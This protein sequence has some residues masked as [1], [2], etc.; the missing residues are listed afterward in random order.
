MNL[1]LHNTFTKTKEEFVPVEKGKVK[2]YMCGPTVYDY[3]HIGNARAFIAGDVLRRFLKYLGYDVTYVLNLTDID[4]KIIKRSQEE[5]VP[6]EKI[7]EKFST[8]FFKDIDALGIEKADHYPK[9]TEHVR[10]IIVLIEKLIDQGTAYRANGDVYYD[11]SKFANYGKLSG[12]NIDDLWA[13]ARV[14]V[15]EK[16]RNPLDFA[17]WKSQKPG[18]PAWESPW[19]M[20]RP[21]WHIECSAMSMKYLGES[22][23]I[24]AG[25]E[26]LIFPHH[27]NEI[28]Q[29]EGATKQK[30][31]KYWLH[32]GFLQ[33][34]GEKM[35]KSLGNFRTVREVVKIYPGRVLR[36]F[37]LQKNYRGPIDLTD[38]GLKAAE[39][40]SSRLKIFY[41]KLS[42]VL[43]NA[44]ET[45]SKDIDLKAL[46]KSEA[47]F[48]DSFEKMKTDLVEA[49]SDDLNTPV[50]LSALFDLVRETNKL[51]SKEG[52]SENEKLL[53]DY[54]KKNFDDF[55]SFLG[56][57]DSGEEKVDTEIVDEL[58]TLLIELRNALRTKKEWALSDKIRDQLNAK[59]IILE[60]KGT[61][62]VWRFK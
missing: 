39:S 42:K 17:L 22:F 61:E 47:E 2:F 3:I 25:G 21:G 62:T 16:K 9:A 13:G 31:V 55:N 6:T 23:D 1:K 58:V 24:H 46:S 7:T 33:I 41:D 15:D 4:D 57:I 37:F 32:N 50:A 44:G 8:A 5:G 53:L 56:L 28:A 20:G 59:G 40:A 52:L 36:L 18:E 27:E 51:L 29:S 10:E 54:S 11:V 34:E 30:F 43:A 14:A 35:A 26:D 19:G 48:Y 45:S 12:K 38:H 60:D 49:M